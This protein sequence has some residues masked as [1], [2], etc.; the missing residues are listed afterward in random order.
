[1]VQTEMSLKEVTER[2]WEIYMRDIRPKVIDQHRGEFLVVDVESGDYEVGKNP[3]AISRRVEDRH[4]K[5]HRYLIRVGYKT[6]W[7]MHGGLRPPVGVST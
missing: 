7:S 2:G 4:P 1:M 3:T 5:G 6:A